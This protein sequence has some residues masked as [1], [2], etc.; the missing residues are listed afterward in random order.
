MA[1]SIDF[2]ERAIANRQEGH[3]FEQLYEAFEI[4]SVNTMIWIKKLAI[5]YYEVKF[6]RERN[7]KKSRLLIMKNPPINTQNIHKD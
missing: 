4:S 5:G 6:K 1:Y 3:T 7:R 2:I